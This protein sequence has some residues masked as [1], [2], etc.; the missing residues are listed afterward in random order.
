MGCELKKLRLYPDLYQ[1]RTPHH[2]ALGVYGR[3]NTVMIISPG[4]W[5][6]RMMDGLPAFVIDSKADVIMN[7]RM[8]E[9]KKAMGLTC[10]KPRA[11]STYL[12]TKRTVQVVFAFH[13]DPEALEKMIAPPGKSR[14]S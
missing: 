10:G 13:G 8:V 1:S 5:V 2:F 4:T 9:A 6:V 14:P 7:A 3:H 11:I 12:G